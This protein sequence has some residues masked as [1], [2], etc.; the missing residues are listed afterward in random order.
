MKMLFIIPQFLSGGS[1]YTHAPQ[2]IP[3]LGIAYMSAV[4]KQ[5]GY[6]VYIID[7]IAERL[8][9]KNLMERIKE[10]NPDVVGLTAPTQQIY[11]AYEIA[12]IVKSISSRTITV[13]GGYHASALP[14]QTLK[15][16]DSF[17]Y[18]IHG[19][20]EYALLELLNAISKNNIEQLK[21][22]DG[23]AYREGNNVIVNL[24]NNYID[25]NTLPMPDFNEFKLEIYK[26]FYTFISHDLRELPIMTSRGCPYD[27]VFCYR[28]GGDIVRYRDI[29]SVIEEIKRDIDVYGVNQILFVDE[30][31]TLNMKR[32]SAICDRL[33]ETGLS[34]RIEWGCETRVDVVNKELLVKMRRAGCR[35]I[36][37]GIESGAQEI[38]DK[39]TKGLKIEDIE[40]AVQWTKEADIQIYANFI[41]GLP[42]DTEETIKKTIRF[43]IGLDPDAASFSILT[44]FPGTGLID[45]VKKGEGGLKI[46]SYDWRDYGKQVGKSLELNNISRRKLE[47]LQRKAY[48]RFYIRPKKFINLFK[49]IGLKTFIK[50]LL[51]FI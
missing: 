27:C 23:L 45:M 44:P 12:S 36:S 51:D 46:I 11:D 39:A 34:K 37:Y 3:Y 28:S 35:V 18:L 13:I 7:A 41:I 29:E 2:V 22:I 21:T 48:M 19:E 9:K 6:E 8:S 20:G 10:I 43:S 33:I 1:R 31:F 40:K 49:I 26:P 15:D 4:I 24:H 42:Y 16:F 50:Y 17:D 5:N 47:A 32:T 38:L 30:T 14:E 25:L